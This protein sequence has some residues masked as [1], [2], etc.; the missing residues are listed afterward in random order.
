VR[1]GAASATAAMVV[2]VQF[3]L[4]VAL[5]DSTQLGEMPAGHQA[6]REFLPFAGRPKPIDGAVRP[7]ALLMRLIER[8]AKAEHA[9]P[10]SPILDNLLLVRSLKVEIAEDAEF[11]R[12]GLDR[13]D[14]LNI[15]AFPE[16]AGW[17]DDRRVDT[18][19]GHFFQRIIHIIGRYLPML[20]RHP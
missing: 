9:R 14:R 19:L 4:G 18:G 6:D 13:L 17:M 1:S 15:G 12:I 16:R 3:E 7:P 10:L 2:D 8:K 11:L 20:R 5:G